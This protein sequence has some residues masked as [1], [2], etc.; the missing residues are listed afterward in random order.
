MYDVSNKVKFE[1]IGYA[2][3][4]VCFYL[5][6]DWSVTNL[7]ILD[8]T[9]VKMD[10][11]LA[12]RWFYVFVSILNL[13]LLIRCIYLFIREFLAAKLKNNVDQIDIVEKRD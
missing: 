12:L 1:L 9:S 10:D 6:F 13:I 8:K 3:L 11:N 2:L 4:G 5:L 7:E